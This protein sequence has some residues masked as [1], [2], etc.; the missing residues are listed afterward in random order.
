MFK[1][2]KARGLDPRPFSCLYFK[3]SKLTWVNPPKNKIYFVFRMNGLERNGWSGP[4]DKIFVPKWEE[5]G[6]SKLGTA[7]L[8]DEGARPTQ[9]GSRF[10]KMT[11]RAKANLRYHPQSGPQ[12]FSA[13]DNASTRV[14]LPSRVAQST[15]V[16]V[17]ARSL[18]LWLR[19][20]YSPPRT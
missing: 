1:Q 6:K 13:R 16:S 10:F 14:P 3:S 18:R 20:D 8:A 12:Y 9:S 11:S 5:R 2:K 4:L 7:G 17:A 15:C 19:N